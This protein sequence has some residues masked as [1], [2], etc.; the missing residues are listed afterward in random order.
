MLHFPLSYV[1]NLP[2][3]TKIKLE[4]ILFVEIHNNDQCTGDDKC[5]YT[6]AGFI[7][8]KLHYMKWFD[9]FKLEGAK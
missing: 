4:S 3:K 5:K 2:F 1:K 7:Y 8:F 9:N 6:V